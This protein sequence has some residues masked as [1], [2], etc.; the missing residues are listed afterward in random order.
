MPY[1]PGDVLAYSFVGLCM[2]TYEYTWIDVYV[3]LQMTIWIYQSFHRHTNLS[4]I[5]RP[6]Y[7]SLLNRIRMYLSTFL[8]FI[9]P[10][11]DLLTYLDFPRY[12]FLS[13]YQ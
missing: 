13:P 4:S 2:Y 5:Y 6:A 1:V 12:L 9:Y 7:L 11:A 10:T 8:S 3:F